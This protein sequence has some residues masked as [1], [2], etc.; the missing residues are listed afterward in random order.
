[1]RLQPANLQEVF[2]PLICNKILFRE[3]LHVHVQ[4]WLL[5]ISWNMHHQ[6]SCSVQDLTREGSNPIGLRRAF[7]LIE[8]LVVIA[9][10]AI[11]A[12]LLLPA[13]AKAKEKAQRAQCLSNLRQ[14]GLAMIFYADENNGLVPRGNDAGPPEW[15]TLF[16]PYLGG[17][18]TNEFDR[19][20]VFLCPSYSN[21][22]NLVCYVV[23]AW[24][25]LTPSPSDPGIQLKPSS[26]LTSV[27]VP[28]ETGYLVDVENGGGVPVIT[29]AEFNQGYCDFFA[30]NALPYLVLQ[31][32]P[33][34]N[35][36]IARRVALDRHGKGDNILYF[37]SH[38]GWKKST[39][40]VK[41]DF[42]DRRY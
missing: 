20:K 13:L 39:T 42:R 35:P 37:D 1:M 24:G 40:I 8:L 27:Q 36:R 31:R 32:G 9:I 15:Y 6:V 29:A 28:V 22:S 25:F 11:L 2:V 16:T 12:A 17:R 38:V 7:T 18:Q 26:K 33:T 4:P 23:N 34:E 3:G 21:K 14:M 19:A 5:T 30:D 10:I 41:N